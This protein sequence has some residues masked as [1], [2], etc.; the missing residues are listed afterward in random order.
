MFHCFCGIGCL[1]V[2]GGLD[3]VPADW[4]CQVA[5]LK[6]SS[7]LHRWP[8]PS[9]QCPVCVCV[10]VSV[11]VCKLN[12][13]CCRPVNFFFFQFTFCTY[14]S[15]LESEAEVEHFMFLANSPG[16]SVITGQPPD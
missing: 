16:W 12:S 6:I 4:L 1:C 5:G 8:H 14:L 10:C 2:I 11:C 13:E 3:V 9:W 15:F 7:H